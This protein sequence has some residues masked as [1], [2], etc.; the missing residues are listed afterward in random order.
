MS[1][2]QSRFGQD[3]GEVEQREIGRRQRRWGGNSG[4]AKDAAPLE[5]DIK[6][7]VERIG[8]AIEEARFRG[9]RLTPPH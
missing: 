1:T 6:R 3:C 2:G 7:A 9:S 8:N 5:L 4:D